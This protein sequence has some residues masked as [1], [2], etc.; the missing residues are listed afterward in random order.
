MTTTRSPHFFPTPTT[1]TTPLDSLTV[2]GTNVSS[3]ILGRDQV[4]RP[5]KEAKQQEKPGQARSASEDLGVTA[6]VGDLVAC[7]AAGVLQ[8]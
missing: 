7:Q 6:I 4:R 5:M 1:A 3:H 8:C 2:L